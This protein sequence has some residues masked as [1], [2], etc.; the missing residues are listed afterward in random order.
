[1]QITPSPTRL[2]CPIKLANASSSSL[3][4]LEK[5]NDVENKN[6]Y[7]DVNKEVA[8]LIYY[9]TLCALEK[10]NEVANKNYYFVK[11]KVAILVATSLY[12]C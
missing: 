9:F 7:F 6:S 3:W 1:M 4:V 10:Y 11:F 5:V 12:M 8:I 2:A